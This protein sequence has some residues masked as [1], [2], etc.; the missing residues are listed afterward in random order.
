MSDQIQSDGE[1]LLQRIK[2]AKTARAVQK[3]HFASFASAIPDQTHIF[4]FEGPDDRLIYHSWISKVAPDISYEA[5]QCNGKRPVLQ[6][7]DILKEDQTGLGDRVYYFVDRD[8][9][10]LQ[11]RP[12]SQRIFLTDCYSVENYVACEQ[13]LEDVLK[14]TFHCNGHINLRRQIIEK[15]RYVYGAFLEATRGINFR[16]FIARTYNIETDTVPVTLHEFLDIKLDRVEV[17]GRSAAEFIML[18]REPSGEEISAALES[19]QQLTPQEHFR[20]KFA[21]LFFARWLGL[22][23]S[24]RHSLNPQVFLDIPVP[25]NAIH[26]D[27]SFPSLATKANPPCN[28]VQFL[29]TICDLPLKPTGIGT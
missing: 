14:V 20:G 11:G 25:I 21:S 15:F 28:L 6:L 3:V 8:F 10:G 22:L 7:F 16:I 12:E 17:L 2:I 19:F 5:Y 27:F 26:G 9:D 29:K 13:V 1:L 23:R 18:R 24:D 4:C